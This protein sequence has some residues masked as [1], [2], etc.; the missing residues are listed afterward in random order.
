METQSTGSLR[1]I[2]GIVGA[3]VVASGL[4][5]AVTQNSLNTW[6]RGLRKARLN[7][8]NWV[9][10]PVWTTLYVF[11]AIA[12]WL[13]W[14]GGRGRP[15]GRRALRLFGV[16]LSLNLLWSILFFGLRSPRFALL[17]IAALWGTITAWLAASARI[18]RWTT[19]LIFPY[20]AWVSF[21]SYLNFEVWRKNRNR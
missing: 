19:L 13:D 21:A 10:G 9:F 16:Q 11:M 3:V 1:T 8:P 20:L 17:D 18:N 15:E 14:R 5:G 7:P 12:A 4:G 2:A 6:Y